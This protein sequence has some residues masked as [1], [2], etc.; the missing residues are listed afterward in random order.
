VKDS[1]RL[2]GLTSAIQE[3]FLTEAWNAL[4]VGDWN[5]P[6]I[7][8]P[9][10]P[11]AGGYD[12]NT[13]LAAGVLAQPTGLQR[14]RLYVEYYLAQSMIDGFGT[15]AITQRGLLDSQRDQDND[16]VIDP[17]PN[18]LAARTGIAANIVNATGA[19]AAG[20]S[21]TV[22]YDTAP[23]ASLPTDQPLAIRVV[24]VWEGGTGNAYGVKSIPGTD[25]RMFELFLARGAN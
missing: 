18:E 1:E 14:L 23:T 22:R 7:F 6:A 12:E 17:Y 2:V 19:A 10:D 3:R 11:F 15:S 5:R 25:A 8:S 24:V 9:T 20:N 13:L 4:G 16:G 21:R